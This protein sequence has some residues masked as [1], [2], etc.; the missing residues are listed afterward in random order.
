MSIAWA[1][2]KPHFGTQLTFGC[3]RVEASANFFDVVA[4]STLIALLTSPVEVDLISDF[5]MEVADEVACIMARLDFYELFC[6]QQLV[7]LFGDISCF[8]KQYSFGKN[9]IGEH[10][11]QSNVERSILS[12]IKSIRDEIK[13]LSNGGRIRPGEY[14]PEGDQTNG[15][16]P[17]F[18]KAK[19]GTVP[20]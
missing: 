6:D 17:S 12:V 18:A 9:S 8:L 10:S 4:I 16:I 15:D 1:V 14:F 2:L 19:A 13:R 5:S 3:G 20:D 7:I 11:W